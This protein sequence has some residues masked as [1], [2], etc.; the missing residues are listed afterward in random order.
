LAARESALAELRRATPAPPEPQTP[1]S[2]PLNDRIERV[3]RDCQE[4]TWILHRYMSRD[5]SGVCYLRLRPRDEDPKRR[6]VAL[7]VERLVV[8]IWDAALGNN[9]FGFRPIDPK[10]NREIR[11]GS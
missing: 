6:T 5:R 8:G 2:I 4:L 3:R 11:T 1:V 7:T 9:T 10:T